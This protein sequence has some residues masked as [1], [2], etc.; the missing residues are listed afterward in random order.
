LVYAGQEIGWAENVPFFSKEP[1]D[2]STGQET[3]AWYA[4]LLEIRENSEPL[5]NGSVADSSN[6]DIVFVR[7]ELGSE[8]IVIAV[9]TRDHASSVTVP[10]SWQGAYVDQ[11][12]G[13]N[14]R[15]RRSLQLDPF[16]VLVLSPGRIPVRTF[17]AVDATNKINLIP[18]PPTV[19]PWVLVAVLLVWRPTVRKPA[20][21]RIVA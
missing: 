12:T 13:R 9:N 14:Q 21:T 17:E 16:Q 15:L 11:F 1:L 2:W 4:S 19:G 7:R 3:L 18:E 6:Q 8:R 5:R 10:V 20:A